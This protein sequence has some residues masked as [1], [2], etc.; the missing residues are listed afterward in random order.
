MDAAERIRPERRPAFSPNRQVGP[1]GAET[2]ARLLR[3]G[4]GVLDAAGYHGARVEAIAESAGCSRPTFYQYFADKADFFF[5]LAAQV[6]EELGALTAAFPAVDRS[7]RSRD[8][9]CAWLARFEG[10]RIRYAPVFRFE[11]LLRSDPRIARGSEARLL[12]TSRIIAAAVDAAPAT[13]A[14]LAC[15]GA[16]LFS[17]ITEA[18]GAAPRRV[19]RERLVEGTADWLHRCLLGPLRGINAAPAAPAARALARPGEALRHVPPV[20][21]PL[22]AKAARS[23]ARLL[24]AARDVFGLLGYEGTRVDDVVSAASMSHGA[25]YRYFSGKDEVFREVAAP[26]VD[27]VLVLLEELPDPRGGLHAWSRRLYQTYAIHRGLFSAWAESEPARAALGPERVHEIDAAA[28]AALG[29]RGFGD[30]GVEALLLLAH[31][32]RAPYIARTYPRF[33]E[34]DAVTAT[35]EILERGFFG[36]GPPEP[37]AG[38]PLTGPRGRAKM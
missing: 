23:R 9:L 30:L 28:E 26:A 8:Q 6:N 17:T 12:A 11:A 7:R 31:L 29:R 13:R 21:A 18:F 15:Q 24:E 16:L 34:P 19:P 20:P 5:H 3:A 36:L 37:A 32:D 10:L 35:G 1:R 27:D 33:A 4:L 14:P 25:F 38:R 2:H 22:G